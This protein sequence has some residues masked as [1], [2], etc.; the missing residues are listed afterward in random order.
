[1]ITV[2][3]LKNYNEKKFFD[4]F[5]TFGNI[6]RS[7][8]IRGPLSEHEIL[9]LQDKF[10]TNGFHYITV[11]DV[12]FGRQLISRFLKTLHCYTDNAVLS[13][14]NL[15]L[16]GSVT[17]IYY[18]LVKGGYTDPT[19]LSDVHEFFVEQFYYDFIWIEACHELVDNNW[20]AEFFRNMI[21]FKIDQHIPVLVISY[22]R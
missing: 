8:H 3:S 12:D 13:I 15:V 21:H 16:N 11:S 22:C 19:K 18:E 6:Q 10:L 20:F 1:M 9:D 14:S 17:D 2:S 4:A 7:K 5:D